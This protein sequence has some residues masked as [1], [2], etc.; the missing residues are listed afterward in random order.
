MK[1]YEKLNLLCG[2]SDTAEDI[3]VKEI[4]WQ[5]ADDYDIEDLY[6]RDFDRSLRKYHEQKAWFE[7]EVEH[8]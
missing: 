4:L 7:S 8:G 3:A 1:K 6:E 5:F 2:T